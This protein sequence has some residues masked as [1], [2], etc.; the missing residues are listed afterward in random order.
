MPKSGYNSELKLDY[1][2]ITPDYKHTIKVKE[3][4]T[5]LGIWMS[6]TGEFSFHIS[7]ILVKVKQRIGWIQ[8]SF[9]TNTIGFK[10]FM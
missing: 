4:I 10:K 8:R 1:V 5:C 6:K 9:K 7:K 2:Y 3:N